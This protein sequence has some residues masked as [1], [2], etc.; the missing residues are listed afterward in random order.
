MVNRLAIAVLVVVGGCLYS[1]PTVTEEPEPPPLVSFEFAESGADEAIDTVTIPVVLS[2]PSAKPV[3]VRCQVIAGGT[4]EEVQDFTVATLD[5]TFAPGVTRAEVA[6]DIVPDN[7]ETETDE[8]IVLALVNPTNATLDEQ[9]AIHEVLI[10]DHILPRVTF[11][12][13]TTTTVESTQ[14]Q[15]VLALTAPSEGV[16]TV[17]IGVAGGATDPADNDDFAITEGTVVSIPND[18]TTISIPIGEI[19]DLRDE[20]SQNVVF[21]LKGAS[22]NLITGAAK[23]A[24]HRIDDNDDPPIASFM[25]TTDDTLEDAGTVM[26]TVR[27]TEESELPISVNYVRQTDTA[28]DIDAVVNGQ[29]VDFAPHT[30]G[31]PGDKTKT[32]TITIDNDGRD[33]LIETVIVDLTTATNASVQAASRYTLRILEDANDTPT[34]QF[35]AATSDATEADPS[36]DI[37]V[38]LSAASDKTVTVSFTVGGTANNGPT[39]TGNNDFELAPGVVTF[40]AGTTSRNISVD[41]HDNDPPTNESGE[42]V[43]VTLTTPDNATLGTPATHTLTISE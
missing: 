41:I 30:F 16:S 10:S 8:T 15:L 18:A 6:V 38:T 20:P 31:V 4:A 1:S 35:A 32:F 22:Q 27:L 37:V 21:E 24:N 28:D 29:A 25:V 33:E 14:T 3:T 2:K 26:V 17:V 40:A 5:V 42:T 9:K 23:I 39:D 13:T 43:V 34:V 7:D 11:M 12:T 36:K 19:D